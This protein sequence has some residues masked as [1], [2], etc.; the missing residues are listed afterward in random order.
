MDITEK[1]VKEFQK[2]YKSKF[3]KD[4]DTQTARHKL[5]L[6]VRQM[7][8]VYQPIKKEQLEEL[9]RREAVKEDA[10]ALAELIYD[11]YQ[12]KKTKKGRSSSSQ[13]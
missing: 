8:I 13:K 2:L 12:D 7:E 3:G 9:A 5:T 11:V 4:V 10:K 6:L 1:D